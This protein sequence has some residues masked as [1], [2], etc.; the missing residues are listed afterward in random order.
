MAIMKVFN[1]LF[2]TILLATRIVAFCP[3][4]LLPAPSQMPCSPAVNSVISGI[5]INILAQWGEKTATIALQEIESK[6]PVDKTAFAAG[7]AVLVNDIM[8][9]IQIRAYNQL[10]AP[11]G[12]AALPGLA[13]VQMEH[14]SDV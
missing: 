13:M 4:C 5:E 6:I 9:G 12:N 3:S 8:F 11:V 10:I 2:T 14:F 7:K 1:F